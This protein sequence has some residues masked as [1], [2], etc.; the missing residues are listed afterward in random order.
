VED[1]G[2]AAFDQEAFH[3][4][5]IVKFVYEW[6][7]PN[8][9]DYP[10]PT[11]P[12]YHVAL[13]GVSRFLGDL[14]SVRLVAALFTVGLLVT[15]GAVVGG[16]V[17]VWT[18]LCLALPLAC[19]LY[20]FSSGAWLLPDNAGWW[21]VLGMLLIALRHRVDWRSYLGAAVVLL[22]TVLVRQTH[23]WTAAP[24][25]VAAWLGP[26]PRAP[27]GVADADATVGEAPSAR[28]GRAA[29]ACAA[30]A[31]AALVL[32]WFFRLW[33]GAMPPSPRSF[34]S[35]VNPAAPAMVLAVLGIVGVFYVGFLAPRREVLARWWPALA[36]GFVVA[37]IIAAVPHTNYDEDAGRSSGLWELTQRLPSYGG[38]S[39]LVIGLAAWGGVVL[40]AWTIALPIRTAWV[41]LTACVAFI[42]AHTAMHEAY[43][44]YYEP[45]AV[46]LFGLAAVRVRSD[47]VAEGGAT[48]TATPSWAGAG[49]LLL[50]AFLAYVTVK[51]LA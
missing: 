44:R 40:A 35:G 23:L 42:A 2:R 16:R 8:F 31:P 19:S 37:A 14:R 38:R 28:L 4:P 10:S 25:V 3:L 22:A 6:P 9:A 21:G 46:I 13:A 17:G 41:F 45:F 15:Y 32:V 47:W 50:A 49:P 33:H 5:T 51:A 1:R 30:T 7:R 43:P 29:L 12:G 34:N 18:G 36:A 20:V 24:L 39:P 48:R 27:R 26:G 11:T